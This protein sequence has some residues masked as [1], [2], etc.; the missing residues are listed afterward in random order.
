MIPKDLR[1]LHFRRTVTS[2]VA[3]ADVVGKDEN[4]IGF[5]RLRRIGGMK[6]WQR[7][8]QQGS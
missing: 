2:E 4:D 1:R 3:V 7:S 5:C 8:Q 6:Q